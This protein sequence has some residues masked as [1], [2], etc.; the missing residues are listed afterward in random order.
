M[1]LRA[2]APRPSGLTDKLLCPGLILHSIADCWPGVPMRPQMISTIQSPSKS[3]P[4]SRRL[5]GA[6]IVKHFS[7]L[8]M[9]QT[10]CE[11]EYYSLKEYVTDVLGT[12]ILFPICRKRIR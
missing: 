6:N 2:V 3:V 12:G 10:A 7:L 5:A 8:K 11:G 4:A 1:C 9:H